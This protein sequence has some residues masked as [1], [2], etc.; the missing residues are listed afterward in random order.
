MPQMFPSWW[1]L[2]MMFSLIVTFA[3][4]SIVF[5]MV[6][7]VPVLEN[8]RNSSACLANQMNIEKHQLKVSCLYDL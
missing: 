5:F 8:S 3:V 1:L 7:E 2:L 4:I 6:S